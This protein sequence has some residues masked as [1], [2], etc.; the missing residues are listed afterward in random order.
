MFIFL[1]FILKFL[2]AEKIFKALYSSEEEDN[3]KSLYIVPYRVAA[4][5]R[6]RKIRMLIRWLKKAS[7]KAS[8]LLFSPKEFDFNGT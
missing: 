1:F 2:E 3:I 7:P 4:K 8:Y 6:N 5:K